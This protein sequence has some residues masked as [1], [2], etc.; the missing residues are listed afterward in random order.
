[1]IFTDFGIDIIKKDDEYHIRYDAGTISMIQ[2]EWKITYEKQLI[3]QQSEKD[4]YEFIIITQTREGENNP[5]T[6]L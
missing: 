5:T 2:K 1:M 4:T 3:A 6:K